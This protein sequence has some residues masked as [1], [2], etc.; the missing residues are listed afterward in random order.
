MRILPQL[1]VKGSGE[2]GRE[3][4]EGREEHEA[5]P[6][7]REKGGGVPGSV[8][9]SVCPL[10]WSGVGGGNGG[11]DLTMKG[12]ILRGGSRWLSKVLRNKQE[13]D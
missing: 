12:R 3:G 1:K 7:A 9:S 2:G 5:R 11:K 6:K 4:R 13:G 10:G 8:R